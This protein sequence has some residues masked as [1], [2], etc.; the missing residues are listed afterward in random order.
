VV[1]DACGDGGS[2]TVAARDA[3]SALARGSHEAV[4][5]IKA[6]GE[7]LLP[8][9]VCRKARYQPGRMAAAGL[10]SAQHREFAV[11]LG[12]GSEQRLQ[13]APVD[14][15]VRGAGQPT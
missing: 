5:K 8:L 11:P 2:I 15:V 10:R 4:T 3:L 6:A 12:Y 13:L 9:G 14:G 1:E 7:R